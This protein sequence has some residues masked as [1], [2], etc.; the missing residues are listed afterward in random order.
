M[1][2]KSIPVPVRGCLS[3]LGIQRLEY[4]VRLPR[5]GAPAG[6]SYLNAGQRLENRSA[7]IAL[8]ADVLAESAKF[9]WRQN[10][11]AEFNVVVDIT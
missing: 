11:P 8:I 10:V 9:S 1:G 6:P 3:H 5:A 4:Q 7:C 2:L